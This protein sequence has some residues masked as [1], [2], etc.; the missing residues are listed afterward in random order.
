VQQKLE[1]RPRKVRTGATFADAAAEHLRYIGEDRVRKASTVEDYLSI[2]RVHR[3]PAFGDAA[4]ES[5]SVGDVEA[6]QV[7]L[8]A[9]V[10]VAADER[11]ASVYVT[12]AFTGL[13]MAEL[14]ALRWRNVDFPRSVIRVRASHAEGE[15]SVPKSG[16]GPLGPDGA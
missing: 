14:R 6:F 11:D 7:R 13:R 1:A 9:L 5:I 8:W 2:I 10:R 15:L 3:L 12:A 4:L 16:K